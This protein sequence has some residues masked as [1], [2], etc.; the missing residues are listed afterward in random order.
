MSR[1]KSFCKNKK[2]EIMRRNTLLKEEGQ[3][4]EQMLHDAQILR[5]NLQKILSLA[6]SCKSVFPQEMEAVESIIQPLLQ[7]MEVSPFLIFAPS[8]L[9]PPN[10]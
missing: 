7:A 10:M 6:N 9:I 3:K 1:S 4:Y 8:L 5:E 2:V